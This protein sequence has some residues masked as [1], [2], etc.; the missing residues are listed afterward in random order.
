MENTPEGAG[1]GTSGLVGQF[2]TWAAMYGSEPTWY[3]LLKMLL[4]SL[5]HI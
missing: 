2:G 3:I 5:I 1:M 4:L